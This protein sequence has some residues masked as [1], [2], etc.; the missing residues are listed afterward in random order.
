MPPDVSYIPYDIS[1]REQ[2]GNIIKFAQ[3]EQ[4]NLLSKTHDDWACGNK[5]NDN[6]IMPPIISE[7]EMDAMYS[8]D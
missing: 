8:G 7:E 6:S 1:L 5:T 4:R 3:F 2:T